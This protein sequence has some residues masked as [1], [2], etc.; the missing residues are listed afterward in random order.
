MNKYLVSIFLFV[1][2][3]LSLTISVSAVTINSVSVSDNDVFYS[4]FANNSIVHLLVNVTGANSSDSAV[5]VTADF[6]DFGAHC[7]GPG[8]SAVISLTNNGGD[9]WSGNCIV[10][11]DAFALAPNS[12]IPG[13]VIVK[14][15]ETYGPSSSNSDLKIALYNIGIPTVPANS[16][17]K[18]VDGST[19]FNQELNFNNL[20]IK[21]VLQVNDGNCVLQGYDWNNGWLNVGELTFN[22]VNFNNNV[23]DANKLTHL[24]DFVKLQFASSKTY[25]NTK[26]SVDTAQL[27]ELNVIP[28]TFK[29]YHLSLL[30]PRNEFVVSD[31]AVQPSSI[32]WVSNGFDDVMQY[33]TYNLTVI[34]ANKGFTGFTITDN[35]PPIIFTP[36]T[37][38][39]NQVLNTSTV[40]FNA[41][42]NGT[43]TEI[44]KAFFI[45]N[46][47]SNAANCTAV[48]PNSEVYNC[49]LTLTQDDGLYNLSIA[50]YDFGG[51]SGNVKMINLSYIVETSA[52]SLI[53]TSPTNGV[54]YT[55]TA[56]SML[57]INFSTNDGNGIGSCGYTLSGAINSGN[58][59]I[60]DCSGNVNVPLY[61]QDGDYSLYI[62]STDTLGAINSTT[63]SFT[64]QDTTPPVII[65]NTQLSNKNTTIL[66]V[67]TDESATC[68][69]D[70]SNLT[71]EKMHNTFSNTITMHNATITLSEKD[72]VYNYYIRCSD[73]SSNVDTDSLIIPLYYGD[74]TNAVDTTTTVTQNVTH[75]PFEKLD[76]AL[77]SS[78]KNTILFSKTSNP[79][80]SIVLVTNTAATGV[81]IIATSVS[82]PSN[83]YSEKVYKYITIDHA[84]ISDSLIDA[85]NITFRVDKTW[86]TNNNL[87]KDNIVLVRYSNGW[88]VL[89]TTILREDDT[90]IYYLA[91]SPGL[92]LFAISVKPKPVVVP[93]IVTPTNTTTNSTSAAS[94]LLSNRQHNWFWIILLSIIVFVIL[95][96]FVL[97]QQNDKRNPP[98]FPEDR[99]AFG[100]VKRL[101]K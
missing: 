11:E 81:T 92:S 39:L 25:Q 58:I 53:I 101:F 95:V 96:L 98:I 48:V 8:S 70:T 57:N 15:N 91:N 60:L 94:N 10:G 18:F 89:N 93:V 82:A 44:S 78:G 46:G 24:S 90:S 99:T 42:V 38:S 62:Y 13:K 97:V 4:S 77:L 51:D 84:S 52:P 85:A 55:G 56:G 30:A 88:N 65:N 67:I 75:D 6:F 71:Y 80:S 26:V 33:N 54:T 63:I 29:L 41:L 5:A 73:L 2:L 36:Y 23:V 32:E 79:I 72:K 19:N 14:A 69:Y 12:F 31:N 66:S 61:L 87:T 45:V 64:V 68:K 7:T 59:S 34:V 9:I 1:S 20:I 49:S 43:G 47:V 21:L 37:P 83:T 28:F 35:I 22:S 16:C 3:F 27:P 74:V 50:A 40:L 76:F 17:F 86:L 100:R